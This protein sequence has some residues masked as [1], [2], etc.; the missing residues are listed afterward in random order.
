MDSS[1][2]RQ[3]Q[4]V[5][6]SRELTQPLKNSRQAL[7]AWLSQLSAEEVR[8]QTRDSIDLIVDALAL[9]PNS[10]ESA[11]DLV[12]VHGNTGLLDLINACTLRLP[13]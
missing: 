11:Q 2:W 3:F 13:I 12:R 1:L 10:H 9:L 4:E 5:S 7:V 6:T 8:D